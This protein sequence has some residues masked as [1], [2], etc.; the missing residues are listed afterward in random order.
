[1][2]RFHYP[3]FQSK[4]I[5]V[6][7]NGADIAK[8]GAFV[9]GTSSIK[10]HNSVIADVRSDI[11]DFIFKCG[12]VS[13]GARRIKNEIPNQGGLDLTRQQFNVASEPLALKMS[14]PA[15]VKT[16]ANQNADQ[17]SEKGNEDFIHIGFVSLVTFFVGLIIGGIL[18]LFS[19]GKA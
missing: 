12:D 18:P 11:Q 2:T 4:P 15:K 8:A 14:I 13:E 1:M 3:F 5:C 7:F 10:L 19:Y 9:G 6:C 16:V 17:S